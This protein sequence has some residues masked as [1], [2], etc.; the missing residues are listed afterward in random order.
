MKQIFA[1]T[2]R[3]IILIS[4]IT[5]VKNKRL[6][7]RYRVFVGI[8]VTLKIRFGFGSNPVKLLQITAPSVGNVRIFRK[9]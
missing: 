6:F 1:I 3:N 7:D 4:K 8:E 2:Y 5:R 9:H